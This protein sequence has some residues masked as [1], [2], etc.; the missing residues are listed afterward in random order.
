MRLRSTVLVHCTKMQHCQERAVT[1]VQVY[2]IILYS[3]I[4]STSST[5]VLRTQV[6]NV[7]CARCTVEAIGEISNIGI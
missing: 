6:H 7:S 1:S 3:T 5:I 4:Y 2:S